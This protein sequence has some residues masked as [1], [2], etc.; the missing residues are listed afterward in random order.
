MASDGGW[1]ASINGEGGTTHAPTAMGY[2]ASTEFALWLALV[3]EAVAKRD[4]VEWK[5]PAHYGEEGTVARSLRELQRISLQR[6]RTASFGWH[7][8][9]SRAQ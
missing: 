6:I 5:E 7:R 3:G 4:G 9:I 1:H 8:A 2:E